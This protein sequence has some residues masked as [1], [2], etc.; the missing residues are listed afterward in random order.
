[1]LSLAKVINTFNCTNFI[2]HVRQILQHFASQATLAHWSSQRLAF[3]LTFHSL[4]HL[5]FLLQLDSSFI[6]TE[7][8]PLGTSDSDDPMSGMRFFPE[9]GT[10]AA[11]EASKA[12]IHS[13]L[14]SFGCHNFVL[15]P[16]P[17]S[18]PWKLTTGDPQLAVAVG[19]EFKKIGVRAKSMSSKA[20]LWKRL[21]WPLMIFGKAL[22]A[23]SASQG[24]P[25]M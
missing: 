14:N 12:I 17:P 20:Q 9:S 1:M 21:S 4:S 8:L 3:R 19:N 24:C 6:H 15:N 7:R 13:F 5:L 18:A 11:P 16:P 23:R 22:N 25:E 2:H 10:E